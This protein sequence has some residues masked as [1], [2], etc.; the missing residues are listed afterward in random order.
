MI[1]DFRKNAGM[2]VEQWLDALSDLE[3]ALA[4]GIVPTDQVP[5]TQLADYYQHMGDLARGYEKDPDKLVDHLQV[6]QSWHDEIDKL[7]A[8]LAA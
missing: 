5:L 7:M 8:L 1:R 2:T 3:A 6:I 4:A